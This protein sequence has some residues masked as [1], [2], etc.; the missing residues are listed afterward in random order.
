M[1]TSKHIQTLGGAKAKPELCS[2]VADFINTHGASYKLDTAARIHHFLG[3]CF[4]ES[5]GFSV[6][7]ENLNYSAAGLQKTFGRHRITLSDCNA[8]GSSKG[9]PANKMQ[10]ANRIYGG[11]FGKKNLGNTEPSDGWN[12]RGSS[13]KQITGRANFRDFT[14]WIRKLMP[15]AP[16]FEANPDKLRTMEWA[17]WPAAWFWV[18]K[19]C[20]EFADRND[21]TG[22]TKRINGGTNGLADRER[23]T[24]RAA[25]ITGARIG[26][27]AATAAQPQTAPAALPVA[28]KPTPVTGPEHDAPAAAPKPAPKVQ[29]GAMAVLFGMIAAGAGWVIGQV[30]NGLCAVPL[31]SDLFSQCAN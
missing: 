17:V 6:I 23:A 16:D 28:K 30:W 2:A 19:G 8:F 18:A 24:R 11:A 3:Q 27:K 12:F 1:I 22:L 5:G 10:I 9:R 29:P 4:V 15:S 20:Y 7:E 13:I 21:V 14:K 26:K 25:S 31:L